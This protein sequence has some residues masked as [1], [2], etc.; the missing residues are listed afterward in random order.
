[1]QQF[2]QVKIKTKEVRKLVSALENA[3]M[4]VTTTNK[5]HI[6]V[7]NPSTNQAVFFGAQSLGDF[8]AGKNILRDL[9]KIGFES[10]VKL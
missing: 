5:R 10:D 4:T 8:R 6:K 7:T 3:G 9:K 2:A 1:M